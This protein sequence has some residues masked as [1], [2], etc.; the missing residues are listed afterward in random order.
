MDI[1]GIANPETHEFG[2][3]YG[4]ATVS[5]YCSSM[6]KQTPATY[7]SFLVRL[8]RREESAEWR[9]LAKDVQSGQ[10]YHF[11][12]ATDCL[13]FLQHHTVARSSDHLSDFS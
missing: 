7:H 6:L 2:S 4:L 5:F 12:N 10:T 8:W 3:C 1:S 11:A 13:H 9:V